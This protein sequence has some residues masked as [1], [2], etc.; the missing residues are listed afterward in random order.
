[1]SGFAALEGLDGDGDAVQQVRK[2]AAKA[3][4]RRRREEEQAAITFQQMKAKAGTTNWADDSD[5][6]N[7]FFNTQPVSIEAFLRMKT[8]PVR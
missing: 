7:E 1:M 4:E 5:E 3:E 8:S 2:Q 6:E